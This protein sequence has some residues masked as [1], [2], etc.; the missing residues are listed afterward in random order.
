MIKNQLFNPGFPGDLS[1]LD[2]GEVVIRD[3]GKYLGRV[4]AL[5]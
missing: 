3:I 1:G 5:R 2:R 4:K